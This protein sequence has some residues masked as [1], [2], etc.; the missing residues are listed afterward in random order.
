M[1]VPVGPDGRENRA[2]ALLYGGDDLRH[3]AGSDRADTR[4]RAGR[5]A[6]GLCFMALDLSDPISR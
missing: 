6:V 2:A 5:G 1:M 4:P 3:P